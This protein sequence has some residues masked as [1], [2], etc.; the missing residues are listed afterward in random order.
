[1]YVMKS[2]YSKRQNKSVTKWASIAVIGL[3]SLC[4]IFITVRFLFNDEEKMVENKEKTISKG[5][6]K[7]TRKTSPIKRAKEKEAPKKVESEK[8]K[9][10]EMVLVNGK[11]TPRIEDGIVKYPPWGVGKNDVTGGVHRIKTIEELVF[12][13]A[14][15]LKIAGLLTTEPGE[16]LIGD[17]EEMFYRDFKKDF[18]KSLE[19]P[20][21][22]E[23]DDSPDVVALKKAV[24]ETRMELKERLDNGEDIA[25]IMI[26]TRKELRELGAY[27]EEL[28]KMVEDYRNKEAASSQD[29]QDMVN[30]TNKMLEERG[31]KKITMPEFYYKQ[32]DLKAQLQKERGR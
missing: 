23:K 30:A 26:D 3:L 12:K 27:R 21:V 18:L 28:K 32:I 22:I 7:T 31:A 11:P 10:V 20:I 6:K 2:K 17:N 14:G 29:L 8:E 16:M 13:N 4:V 9:D 25:Q 15:D 5:E 19:T 24:H 1:M